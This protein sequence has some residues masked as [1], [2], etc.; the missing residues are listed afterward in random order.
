MLDNCLLLLS[1]GLSSEVIESQYAKVIHKITMI[2]NRYKSL[3]KIKY[4]EEGFIYKN[5]QFLSYAEPYGYSL[6]VYQKS[7][8][9]III[10]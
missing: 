10:N 8:L 5:K 3:Y 6:L 4:E 2:K 7:F 1:S 9:E